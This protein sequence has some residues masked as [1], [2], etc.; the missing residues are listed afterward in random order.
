MK[1]VITGASGGIG[2]HLARHFGLAGHEIWGLARSP[3][4]Q[5]QQECAAQGI[6]FRCSQADIAEWPQISGVSREVAAAWSQLDVLICCAGVQGPLGPGMA[7]DP[8]AWSASVRTN[9]DGTY[10]TIRAFH[11]LLLRHAIPRAK[12]L[13]LSGGGSTSPRLNFT[14]YAAAKTGLVRLVETLALEW[15]GG[16]IDINAIAPGAINTRMTEE[17]LNSGPSVVG[18]KEFAIATRQKREGGA[19]LA[20]VAKMFELLV[21]PAADNISGRLISAQWDPWE[22]LSQ[23]RKELAETDI[24]TLRRIV[25]RD[26]GKNWAVTTDADREL[27][28]NAPAKPRIIVLGLWHM[29]SVTAACCARHFNVVGLEFD[30]AVVAKLKLGKAPLSEPGLDDLIS[31]GLAAKHLDFTTDPAIACADADV[32]WLCYDTP[33]NEHDESDVEY[34]LANLRRALPQLPKGTL[35]LI[36]AQL[37]VGTCRRLEAE[38]P[39][40]H[41]ACSPEN[42][43]LGKALDS[44]ERAERVIVGVRGDAKKALL[45]QLFAPFTSQVIFMRTESAEMVKH[46]LNSFLAL[47]I[48]FINEIARLCEHVGAD[49]KEVSIGLKS[50]PRIGPQAYL[51]PGGPFAGGTLAR[52]VVT[53]AGLGAVEGETLAVIPAIKQSNDLHRGWAFRRLQ[54]RLGD[55]HGKTIAVLGLVYTPNTDTLRRS[56]AVELC[57]QLVAAGATVRTCDPA[58][59]QLPAELSAVSLAS[60]AADAVSGAD[61]AVVCTRWPQ[62]RTLDWPAMLPK[63]RGRVIVDAN[64]FLEKELKDLPGVEH[65]SVGRIQ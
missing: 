28:A 56:A 43:R 8:L 6:S 42:L 49:A 39:Q 63:M 44:F 48:T 30:P 60:S 29:G 31:A 14:P 50:D 61:A 7:A 4:K 58:I 32:L 25:P 41:F 37:P 26:R 5:F 11:D 23:H 16:T 1:I 22:A 27:T 33:V 2:R 55:V 47:S 34:V 57:H 46:A 21:S 51:G 52:D 36:S 38:Y 54:S 40:F 18:E 3:Q 12:V 62:F 53:L 15:S 10:Y 17:V 19:S 64:R 35:V 13:C 24:F 59:K 9:L 65:L 20:R 45:Q